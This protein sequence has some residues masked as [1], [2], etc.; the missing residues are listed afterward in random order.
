MPARVLTT[1]P[2]VVNNATNKLTR[3]P[4]PGQNRPRILVIDDDKEIRSVI[5]E[6]L[7]MSGY[8][9]IEA[10]SGQQGIDHASRI[11]PDLILLDV[12]MPGLDGWTVLSKLQ[13]N[14]KVAD[15]PVIVLGDV[16]M[17]MSLGAASVLFKPVDASRLTAE[18]AAHLG[19]MPKGYVLLVE[20]DA[21]SRTLITRLLE[22]EGWQFRAANN[23]N[24]AIRALRKSLPAM[25]VLDLKMPGMN[26][27][28][29][30]E[31]LGRNPVWAKIPVIVITSMDVTQEFLASRTAGILRKGQ[32]T[33]EILADLIRPAVQACVLAET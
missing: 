9:V 19:P 33:R 13:D 23:G 1:Q 16:E 4:F 24:A 30:L 5:T 21:D 22:R 3:S 31:V 32:F 7:T 28:E 14:P 10:A 2:K 27:L 8:D 29:L 20:D 15:V 6:L 17:A 25:I 18:I 26:G 12:M 11:V